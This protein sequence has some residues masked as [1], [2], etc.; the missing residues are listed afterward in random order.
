MSA[1]PDT[2]KDRDDFLASLLDVTQT[3]LGRAIKDIANL[4]QERRALLDRI[5]QV[6]ADY[7][8]MAERIEML[9]QR[10]QHFS[11]REST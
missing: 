10:L 11:G 5:A 7:W 3:G 8:W 2:T 4:R 6:P 1:I 9:E